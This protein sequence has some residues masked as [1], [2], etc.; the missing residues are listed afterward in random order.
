MPCRLSANLSPNMWWQ[1]VSFIRYYT[2]KKGADRDFDS[3]HSGIIV[4][5]ID[6]TVVVL[7]IDYS[8]KR[9]NFLSTKKRK[10]VWKLIFWDITLVNCSD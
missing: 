5:V 10:V 3:S 8:I 7:L 2:L 9:K 1:D 6:E 4:K